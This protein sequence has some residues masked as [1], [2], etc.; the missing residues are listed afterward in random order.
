M[1]KKLV[2]LILGLL[3]LSNVALGFDKYFVDTSNYPAGSQY[4]ELS[5]TISSYKLDPADTSWLEVILLD[6]IAQAAPKDLDKLDGGYYNCTLSLTYFKGAVKTTYTYQI[7]LNK[8]TFDKTNLEFITTQGQNPAQQA[9]NVKGDVDVAKDAVWITLNEVK[10]TDYDR[11]LYVNIDPTNLNLGTYNGAITITDKNSTITETIPVSLTV[12]EIPLQFIVN[13]LS[14]NFSAMAGNE[15]PEKQVVSINSNKLFNVDIEG[16]FFS[17][18]EI[19][20]LDNQSNYNVEVLALANGLEAGPYEGK[21]NFFVDGVIV[22]QLPVFLLVKS[23]KIEHKNQDNDNGVDEDN[24]P[25]LVPDK[26]LQGET[27]DVAL[28]MGNPDTLKTSPKQIKDLLDKISANLTLSCASKDII[29]NKVSLTPTNNQIILNLTVSSD[30]KLGNYE[31]VIKNFMNSGPDV[32]LP[33]SIVS[34]LSPNTAKPGDTLTV[35][36]YI[37]LPE[38]TPIPTKEQMAELDQQM[39][40]TLPNVFFEYQDIT[41][42]VISVS[43][44]QAENKLGINLTIKVSPNA[45][46]GVYYPCL[47]DYYGIFYVA[48]E[49]IVSDQPTITAINPNSAPAGT[50]VVITGDNFGQTQGNSHVLFSATNS[51]LKPVIV[52]W[53][54]T[55]IKAIVPS[56]VGK[57]DV[58]VVKVPDASDLS[59]I[60]ESNTVAF[61]ITVIAGPGEAVIYPNPYN[62]NSGNVN[63]VYENVNANLIEVHIYDTTAR[64]V[65]QTSATTSFVTWNGY[66]LSNNIVGDGV[67]LA[68][69]IDA[70]SKKTLAK[71]KILVVRQ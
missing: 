67:Y 42:E 71:G 29:I 1:F 48:N 15:N 44:D 8:I 69:V 61:A 28:S 53:S 34:N 3:C 55:Q 68:R 6:K 25:K 16:E 36:Y 45:Q 70:T 47:W 50:E 22:Y 35:T 62:P 18:S 58:K 26:L 51:S 9:I 33:L 54:N 38:G 60:Q 27:I 41:S 49:T 10:N 17:V 57:H 39:K 24:S 52:S 46:L 5:N 40:S 65:Y 13:P 19:V 37:A 63:I 14:L 23:E 21:I 59:K 12:Q 56:A 4:I 20:S 2:F 32:A 30:A 31:L 66:N 11:T 7:N 43:Y 64:K